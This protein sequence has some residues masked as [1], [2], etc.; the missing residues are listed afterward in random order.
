MKNVQKNRNTGVRNTSAPKD[1]Q[2]NADLASANRNLKRL[3]AALSVALVACVVYI[4]VTPTQSTPPQD[5]MNISQPA[6]EAVATPAPMQGEVEIVTGSPGNTPQDAA[7]PAATPTM[8]PTAT[9][10]P[11]A[12]AP[13]GRSTATL[14]PPHGQPGHRCDIAVGSPLP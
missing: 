12:S 11:P 7:P 1:T 8:D 13:T 6:Q 4:V 3:V 9:V 10:S 5:M 14:N 2:S